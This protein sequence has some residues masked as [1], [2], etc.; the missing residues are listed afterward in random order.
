M[1]H[2]HAENVH[3]FSHRSV[4]VFL[5]GTEMNCEQISEAKEAE[6]GGFIVMNIRARDGDPVVDPLTDNIRSVTLYGRVDI[7]LDEEDLSPEKMAACSQLFYRRQ[8]KA[9]A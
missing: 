6:V 4:R 7:T 1:L 3:E 5:D 9:S 2:I 8:F